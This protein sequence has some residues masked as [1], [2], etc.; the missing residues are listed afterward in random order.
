MYEEACRKYWSGTLFT[1]TQRRWQEIR[2]PNPR[3]SV[4]DDHQVFGLI[5]RVEV[6]ANDP[7]LNTT[8]TLHRLD[9]GDAWKMEGH[10]VY[11]DGSDDHLWTRYLVAVPWDDKLK[12]SNRISAYDTEAEALVDSAG[13]VDGSTGHE[14][15]MVLIRFMGVR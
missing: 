9:A 5:R 13:I 3:L 7:S 12:V 10:T 15:A 1:A 8:M 2:Q 4:L 11:K 14:R 6:T